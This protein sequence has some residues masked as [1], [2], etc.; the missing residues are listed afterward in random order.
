MSQSELTEMFNHKVEVIDNAVQEGIIDEEV[1]LRLLDRIR[2][3]HF[4]AS[5][6]ISDI[7]HIEELVI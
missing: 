1:Y 4:F 5:E 7:E 3:E 6:V 2:D